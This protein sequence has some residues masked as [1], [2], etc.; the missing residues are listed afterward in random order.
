M[1]FFIRIS[2]CLKKSLF[3]VE[4]YVYINFPN[5]YN[6][7]NCRKE[8]LNVVLSNEPLGTSNV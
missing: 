1:I 7:K 4:Q 2:T 8:R 6:F 3:D 5:S